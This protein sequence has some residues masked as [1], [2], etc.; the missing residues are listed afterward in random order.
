MPSMRRRLIST[1]T[2]AIA[3]TAIAAVAR[4]ADAAPA[5]S[6]PEP[7]AGGDVL[8]AN[9]SYESDLQEWTAVATSPHDS[10]AACATAAGVS[11]AW[12]KS[13]TKSVHLD[14]VPGCS[15]PGVE[16]APVTVSAG[17][18]YTAF[19][20]GNPVHGTVEAAIRYR[21][22]SG[23][24]LQTTPFGHGDEQ[25]VTTA[26]GLA[27]AGT[28]SASVLVVGAGEVFA[29]DVLLSAKFT[30]LGEQI[31]VPGSA[32][33]TTYGK[34][35]SGRDIGYTVVT[36]AHGVDARLVGVDLVTAAITL[37]LPV[38]N[39]MGAWAATT[40][41]DGTIYITGYNYADLT[42]GG[43]L[44]SYHPG[45]SVVND[46]GAPVAGDGF[47]Y[48]ATP[49]PDGSVLGGTYPS[50]VLFR[51]QPGTGFTKLGDTPVSPGIQYVRSVAYDSSTGLVF[52]GTATTSHIVACPVDGSGSCAEVL[53]SSYARLPWVYD[54]SAGD[55]HAFARVT[56]DHG[57]DHLVVIKAS[58]A[59]DGSIQSSVVNDRP[60]IAY[61][62]TSNVIAGSTYYAKAG[63]LYRY[64][65][66]TESETD[67]GVNTGIYARTWSLVQ[68]ADQA[69]YPGYTLVGINAG[70]IVARYNLQTGHLGE[71]TVPQ[72]PKAVVDIESIQGGPDSKVY[73][74]GYLVG[75]LGVYAPMR[76]DQDI[77]LSGGPGYGQAEGMTSLGGRVYQGVYP[78]AH[79][80]S[81]APSDAA[82]G[83]G[84]RIDCEIGN[85]QDR[86]YAMIAA[87]G[88]IYAGTMA[89]YGQL[90]GALTVYDPSTGT[91]DVHRDIVH[92]QSIVSLAESRGKIYGGSLIWGGL[93]APTT[94]TEAKLF[95]F[96]EATGQTQT[97]DLPVRGLR[98]ITSL[99]ATPDGKLWMLAQNYLLVY[100]PATSAW[101]Y[102]KNIFPDIQY[103]ADGTDGGRITAYDSELLIGRDGKIYG[104]IRQKHFFSIDPH[105]AAVT[106]ILDATVQQLTT[107][108]Y[109]N[110]YTVYDVNHLLRYV[111]DRH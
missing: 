87:H 25:S 99:V 105:T 70:G 55:G 88:K 33:G 53:P 30:D 73:S 65:T 13:G 3:A 100:D 6:P 57:E 49:G 61:P 108:G 10:A 32:N 48:G 39:A 43:R 8:I 104:T 7:V 102:S 16:S 5:T 95:A 101:V 85:E 47:L 110:L 79:L 22:A 106:H 29:D 67:L 81:F 103:P 58:R 15:H 56:D 11:T 82:A 2:V 94:E 77:Q 74:A 69:T 97:V 111:P 54:L 76:S 24:V 93:G 44:Y 62:G 38:P 109:G 26:S 52:A 31:D 12:A 50:G 66:S 78:G 40:A 75:G 51:Y 1:L 9:Y 60:G 72:L 20:T 14:P 71:N 35:P 28:A 80:E 107:D 98:S 45:D 64:D 23:T 37:N 86:P 34:D 96:D 41:D 21:D 92:N 27:P 4:T 59:A 68:L 19:V 46:L 83:R 91:C 89:V 18:T 90:A 17:S 84:P 42:I 36:G 63:E